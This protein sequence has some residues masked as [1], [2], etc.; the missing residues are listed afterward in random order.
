MTRT[1]RRPDAVTTIG[2]SALAAEPTVGPEAVGPS[3]GVCRTATGHRFTLFAPSARRV[4]LLINTNKAGAAFDTRRTLDPSGAE[5]ASQ[6]LWSTNVEGLPDLFEY[7]YRLDGG[8]E[9]IDP[10]AR[11]L[12]GGEIWGDRSWQARGLPFRPYRS[13]WS[14]RAGESWPAKIE[15]AGFD[16]GRLARPHV[17]EAERVIYE[18]HVRGFTR[19]ASSGV[20]APGTYRGLIEKIPYLRELGVTTLEL[21]P[22]FEFDETE[23]HRRDPRTGQPLLNFWGYSPISFFAPKR[24]YAAGGE[25]GAELDELRSLVDECHRAG[26]EVVLDVVFNH[27]AEGG[28]GATDPTR[29]FRGLADDV[30]YIRDR[31]TGRPFDCTGCGNTVNSNHPVVRKMI[32]DSLRYWTREVGVDGFRFDLASVFYR[33]VA[34]EKLEASPIAS[35]I[36]AD[37]I[38]AGGLLIAE[39]WDISGFSPPQ[40]FPAP[41]RTW[42]GGFRDDVRRHL[43]GD[44]VAAGRMALRLGG[45]ADLFPP[46]GAGAP[47]RTVDFIACH[48]GFTLEDLVSYSAKRNEANGEHSR[49]GSDFNLSSNH[50]AE[51]DTDDPAIRAARDRQVANGLALL[52]L[53]RNVPMLLGGDERARTQGGNNNPWCQDNDTSWLDWSLDDRGRIELVRRLIALRRELAGLPFERH[54]LLGGFGRAR[55]PGAAPAVLLFRPEE[56]PEGELALALNPTSQPARLPIPRTA[57]ARPWRLAMDT[58]RSGAELPDRSSRPALAT[59]TA[60]IELPPRSLRLLVAQS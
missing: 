19:H 13:V 29:S 55:D 37:P 26:L 46:A 5:G 53:T 59:E 23:N 50:G 57:A 44:E 48:D 41:W 17:A 25:P 14:A 34:G 38:L 11:L 6:G 4:E 24:S 51:G 36:A 31:T 58:A 1:V 3:P 47:P 18:L 8:P 52:L 28:G 30:Y 43:R 20:S 54:A 21:L 10:Y 16:T 12:A 35:E 40:G 2:S 27:T 7:G 60:E 22:I 39:P 15:G 42:N 9:L 32:L 56:G 45:S 49:D 33:G